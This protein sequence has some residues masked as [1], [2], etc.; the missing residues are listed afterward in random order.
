M[1][2]VRYCHKR[3]II[4]FFPVWPSPHHTC[5]DHVESR[6]LIVEL[7]CLSWTQVP[8]FLFCTDLLVTWA[9]QNRNPMWFVSLCALCPPRPTDNRPPSV[10]A[11]GSS[12]VVMVKC[13]EFASIIFPPSIKPIVLNHT[14]S[15]NNLHWFG[16]R[17]ASLSG[18][19]FSENK[20]YAFDKNGNGQQCSIAWRILAFTS[21]RSF[22]RLVQT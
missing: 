6:T 10:E 7:L 1:V 17:T 3:H 4:N 18:M 21:H 22:Y 12:W 15:S 20:F 19:L 2:W 8:F 5:V 14:T 16:S 13:K 9:L 11:L